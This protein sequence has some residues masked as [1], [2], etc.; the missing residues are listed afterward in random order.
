[1]AKNHKGLISTCMIILP[2][3]RDGVAYNSK[4]GVKTV[5]LF[6]FTRL[7]DEQFRGMIDFENALIFE[8]PT[9]EI[10]KALVSETL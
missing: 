1:M 10:Q 9:D 8:T 4:Y 2:L 3:Q 5:E 7:M 6:L